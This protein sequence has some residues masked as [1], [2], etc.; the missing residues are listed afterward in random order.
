MA[1]ALAASG[2]LNGLHLHEYRAEEG[3]E[4]PGQAFHDRLDDED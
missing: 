4:E 3:N 1:A 2:C